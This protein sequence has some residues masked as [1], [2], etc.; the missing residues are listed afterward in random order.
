MA[1][2]EASRRSESFE[3]VRLRQ[4]TSNNLMGHFLK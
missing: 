4:N 1:G 2:T 3:E